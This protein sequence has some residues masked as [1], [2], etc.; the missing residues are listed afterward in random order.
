MSIPVPPRL[1]VTVSGGAP[2]IHLAAGALCAFHEQGVQFEVVATAGAGA[3]PG[4]LYVA[5]RNGDPEEA[6]R[7]VVNLNVHDALYYMIPSNFKVF[8]KYGP[9]SQWFWQLGQTFHRPLPADRFRNAATRLYNDWVDLVTAAITPTTLNYRSRS[10]L[11]RIKVINDLVDWNALR[12]YPGEFF[13]NAFSFKDRRLEQFD[14]N[15]LSP[16][17]FYAALAMPWL[18]APTEYRGVYYTEGAS[19]DPAGL[20]ALYGDAGPRT[21]KV[22]AVIVL[23]TIGPDLWTDP[24]SVYEALQLTIMDP[25]VTL[26]ESLSALVAMEEYKLNRGQARLPKIYRLPFD[27]A[28]WDRG[29]LLEWSYENALALWEAGHRSALEFIADMTP[30]PG[31]RPRGQGRRAAG[32]RPAEKYRQWPGIKPQSREADFLKIFGIDVPA[33]S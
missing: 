13:L 24:E 11:T 17:A 27:V 2:T 4:L 33:S 10:V 20:L 30:A 21:D 23:D 5:P 26:S 3:L 16:E 28:N 31:A 6:L 29:R 18:Y 1:G 15:K 7:R 32:S 12:S 19:H 22:D 14:K 8:H 9:F 25:I